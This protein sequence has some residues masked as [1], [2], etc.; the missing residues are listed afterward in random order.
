M[1]ASQDWMVYLEPRSGAHNFLLNHLLYSIYFELLLLLLDFPSLAVLLSSLNSD[2]H[3]LLVTLHGSILLFL[4]VLWYIF[5]LVNDIQLYRYRMHLFINC[6]VISVWTVASLLWLL[7]TRVFVSQHIF[8]L[9]FKLLEQAD[10]CG[11][12]LRRSSPQHKTFHNPA[13]MKPQ[14]QS[15]RS[16]CTHTPPSAS[17]PLILCFLSQQG[18]MGDQGE[19][20]K[21]DF[22][23]LNS[24]DS[25]AKLDSPL[26][27]I[28]WW[29]IVSYSVFAFG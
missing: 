10:T 18:E 29:W 16:G 22:R 5:F 13:W 27:F 14:I 20:V 1:L 25:S 3:N 15:D 19:K 9:L 12:A 28:L 26:R 23:S 6:L 2:H 7:L 4:C 11:S 24:P 8:F 21:S 17:A